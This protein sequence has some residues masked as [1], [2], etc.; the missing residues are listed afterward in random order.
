LIY[1]VI[2]QVTTNDC[3]VGI[4]SNVEK[5]ADMVSDPGLLHILGFLLPYPLKLLEI[6]LLHAQGCSYYS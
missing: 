6:R 1:R 4:M 5:I 2:V 3:T